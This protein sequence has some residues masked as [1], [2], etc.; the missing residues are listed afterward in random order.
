MAFG[1]EESETMTLSWGG[2]ESCVGSFMDSVHVEM[3]GP[4]GEKKVNTINDV[5]ET[6]DGGVTGFEFDDVIVSPIG[7]FVAD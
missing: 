6:S 7:E 1:G 4:G 3:G 2:E 5:E